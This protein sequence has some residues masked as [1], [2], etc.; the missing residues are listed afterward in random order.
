[1]RSLRLRIELITPYRSK[2]QLQSN[3][4]AAEPKHS[5]SATA[6]LFIATDTK[7]EMNEMRVEL[8]LYGS[9]NDRSHEDGNVTSTV[10]C[11]R[12]FDPQ[13]S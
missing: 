11:C 1:M 7:A 12:R 4:Q 9:S 3:K 6:P 10:D 13:N 8:G 2:C 5:Q